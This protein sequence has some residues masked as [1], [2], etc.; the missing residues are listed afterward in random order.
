M[1][2]CACHKQIAVPLL[3]SRHD[4]PGRFIRTALGERLLIGLL[5][6][7]PVSPLSPISSRDFPCVRLILLL[8]QQAS[9]LLV[10]AHM[11][12]ELQNN[13]VML[14]QQALKVV[15]GG[16]AATPG[17][18]WHQVM[19]PDDQHILLVGTIENA[20]HASAWNEPMEPPEEI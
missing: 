11:Q 12:V 6:I 17:F 2:E 19:S 9:F 16:V 1:N 13:H 18:L 4:I 7:V 3:I 15:N 14:S 10:I 5:I 8:G 20:D